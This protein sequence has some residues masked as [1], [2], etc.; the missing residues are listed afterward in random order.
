[1]RLLAAVGLVLFALGLCATVV[2]PF[3]LGF[4]P[5]DFAITATASLG[6]AAV[7]VLAMRGSRQ[8]STTVLVAAV[9][10][11]VWATMLR[12]DE[13]PGHEVF[14]FANLIHIVIGYAL[15][16]RVIATAAAGATLLYIIVH[17][18]LVVHEPVETLN[19]LIVFVGIV[20]VAGLGPALRSREVRRAVAAESGQTSAQ[21]DY[22]GIFENMAEG[23]AHCRVYFE[24]G[25]AVDFEYLQVNAQFGA[26]TGLHDVIGKR[27]SHLIP[28]F[29]ETD[30][31]LLDLYGRVA[32]GGPPE[33]TEVHVPGL[34]RWFSITAYAAG[35]DEFVAIFDNTTERK[36]VE[37]RLRF[38]ARLLASVRQAVV[39]TDASGRITYWGAG[40]VALYGWEAAEV[41][42]RSIVEVTPSQT[43]RAQAEEI[44]ASLATGKSWSGEFLVSRKDGSSFTALV[45]D[46]PLLD[47]GRHLV[48]VI[49][50]SQDIS[51]MKAATER[52]TFQAHLLESVSQA[53][54]GTDLEGCI[55][56]WSPGAQR[57][58][59]WSRTEA[60]GRPVGDLWGDTLVLSP[61]V[62][63]Q[64][65]SPTGD[66]QMH[67]KDGSSVLVNLGTSPLLGPTGAL[68]GFIAVGQDVTEARAQ[69]IA[70]RR[71]ERALTLISA[72][73][74]ELIRADSEKGLLKAICDIAVVKGGYR[75]AWVGLARETPGHPVEPVAWAGHEA[76]YLKD[77]KVTWD[78]VPH[79]QVSGKSIREGRTVAMRDILQDPAFAP[80]REPALARGFGSSIS[81]FLALDDERG[82]LTMYAP[83]PNDFEADEVA[84]LEEMGSDLAF[85]IRALRL[86]A[87]ESAI[88][89]MLNDAEKL[90]QMGSWEYNLATRKVSWSQ[91]VFRI[92]EVPGSYDPGNAA[93]DI[94]FYEG[95]DEARVNAAFRAAVEHGKPY[96][97]EVA[98][99]TAKGRLRDVRVI[100]IPEL[101]DGKVVRVHGN[102]MDIT[103]QKA[104]EE[105][106]RVS[107]ET[108]RR[109]VEESP[110]AIV[111]V[112]R[113]GRFLSVNPAAVKMY[114]VPDADA[115]LKSNAGDFY[116]RPE[117]LEKRLAEADP[118]HGQS[119]RVTE[120]RRPDG[121]KFWVRSHRQ[122]V[123]GADGKIAYYEGII[124][125]IT[126]Q[127]RAD[128]ARQEL[129][130]KTRDVKRLE[131]LNKMRME[132]LNSAA[133]DLKTPLT[134]LKLQLATF[135]IT[136]KSNPEQKAG[137]D[138][139]ERNVTRFQVLVDDMLDAARLQ[140][141]K[142][143]LRREAVD[144]AP[145]VQEAVA[146]FQETARAAGLQM[147]VAL[148]PRIVID[149]D[150]SKLVQVLMN[151][152]SNAVKYTPKGGRIQVDL[153]DGGPE[154]HLTI[155]DSGLGMTTDQ[156]SRLFQPFVRL[157]EELAVA[158][159]TGL[160]LYISKGITEQHGGRIWAES[161]GPGKGST[162]HLAWPLA[163][164][165]DATAASTNGASAKGAA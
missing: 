126:A 141:G 69:T 13:G 68:E 18:T 9:F 72:V 36:T 132:F 16:R 97:L 14:V 127:R 79:G 40:A 92:H 156:L 134:P 43:S 87:K 55:T 73:N 23:L 125:D 164:T 59:G 140:A 37:D 91:E 11:A 62:D 17:G 109:F 22:R 89:T 124:E 28:G 119:D 155:A 135:R 159:G 86:R 157:H 147:E 26:L 70:L 71:R 63:L 158:K 112:S 33:R 77:I 39:A 122:A 154:A 131:E 20:A 25:K 76:G 21:A 45:N 98:L 4:S 47:D 118:P 82:V 49:G 44:M 163:K 114:G 83:E 53:V 128:E 75:M 60:V 10:A 46:S 30:A 84:L 149:A 85:G 136:G 42:G 152:V 137:L 35:P 102:I 7:Y 150:P 3:L 38:K 123:R 148:A 5:F 31:E 121:T 151:L 19:V 65:E 129:D 50:V 99:T 161:E 81:L 106:L 145:L 130:N 1:L 27:V 138:L 108:N 6:M 105:A 133:H 153:V 142:L 111:R 165:V 100:G 32:H 96:D 74:N 144:L 93:R 78:N 160:G 12:N 94:Q 88:T 8:T 58:F 90:S 143:K 115:L 41:L 2:F 52:V 101:K 104:A 15:G 54:F 146:S 66:Y 120:L 110:L 162:F 51:D 57:L 117:E 67:C 116:A 113:E 56:Y 107:E 24:D 29:R 139:M 103:E 48:G 64:E 34:A 80:W 95:G 61:R